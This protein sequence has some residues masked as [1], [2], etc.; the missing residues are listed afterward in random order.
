MDVNTSAPLR[1]TVETSRLVFHTVTIARLKAG[2]SPLNLQEAQNFL[3]FFNHHYPASNA[4][5]RALLARLEES[6][7][8]QNA[9]KPSELSQAELRP[10]K[11]KKKSNKGLAVSTSTDAA[12]TQQS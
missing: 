1:A 5:S 3:S 4:S 7:A 9:P 11:K 8:S 6:L 10:K 2:S 12:P